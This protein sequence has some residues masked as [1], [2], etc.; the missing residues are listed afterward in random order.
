MLRM[1]P[2]PRLT[3][4]DPAAAITIS[5]IPAQAGIHAAP[6]SPAARA[7][8]ITSGGSPG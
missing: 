7:P 5:V 6:V 3:G 1:V 2:L 4:E 8:W